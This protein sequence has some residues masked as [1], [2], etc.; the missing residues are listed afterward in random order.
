MFMY[1]LLF[2]YISWFSFARWNMFFEI[3][4]SSYQKGNSCSTSRG[5]F[6]RK[7]FTNSDKYSVRLSDKHPLFCTSSLEWLC[8]STV[9]VCLCG[10]DYI[11][12]QLPRC[13]G[14]LQKLEER[15]C[16]LY[17]TAYNSGGCLARKSE[18]KVERDMKSRF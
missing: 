6:L 2:I 16:L 5:I 8:T 18:D 13:D 15:S 1:D 11:L 10:R 9:C 12:N 3:S 17:S 7:L 4:V 14:I